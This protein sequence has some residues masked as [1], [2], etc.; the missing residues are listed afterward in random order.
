[1][2]PSAIK[3]KP[4]RGDVNGAIVPAGLIGSIFHHINR[5]IAYRLAIST[6]KPLPWGRPHLYS[7]RATKISVIN[8]LVRFFMFADCHSVKPCMPA[9][10]KSNKTIC[11]SMYNLSNIF[12]ASSSSSARKCLLSWSAISF[13]MPSTIVASAQ[14][15][16]R[17]YEQTFSGMI[18]RRAISFWIAC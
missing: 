8:S 11:S 9:P 12:S 6:E 16:P 18:L 13:T 4:W 2:I 14:P 15:F 10:A 5:N 7:R 17:W 1:M 3:G